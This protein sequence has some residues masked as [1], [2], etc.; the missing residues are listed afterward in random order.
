[1]VTQLREIDGFGNAKLQKLPYKPGV[2]LNVLDPVVTAAL[3][4]V[5]PP[6]LALLFKLIRERGKT[7]D[8]RE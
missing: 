2:L 4:G 5:I 7:Q 3:I 8:H 6:T 1:M